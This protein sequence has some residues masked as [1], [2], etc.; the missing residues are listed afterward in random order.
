[1]AMQTYTI[2]PT[3]MKIVDYLMTGSQSKGVIYIK[4]PA[5]TYD[6]MVYINPLMNEGWI[7]VVAFCILIPGFVSII[8]FFRKLI[9]H[10]IVLEA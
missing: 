3:R 2:T 10:E 6:W 8:L 4:N 9:K 5:E 1:M 7:G